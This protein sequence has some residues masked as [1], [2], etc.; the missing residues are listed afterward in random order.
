MTLTTEATCPKCGQVHSVSGPRSIYVK[1]IEVCGE[2]L[3]REA[4]E[5][6][7][8]AKQEAYAT[9]RRKLGF[10]HLGDTVVER[11]EQ[12]VMRELLCEGG[13]SVPS[14]L[15]RV[16]RQLKVLKN[17]RRYWELVQQEIER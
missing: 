15:G 2:C 3:V 11:A 13:F 9:S 4:R 16:G 6:A 10:G 12:T 8:N 1:S 7:E 14:N 5:A 17:L